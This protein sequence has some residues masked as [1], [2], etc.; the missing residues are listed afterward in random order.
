M[1]G[2]G[3]DSTQSGPPEWAVPF[4]QNYM[5]RAGAVSDLP[6][7]AYQGQ[8]L[9][10]MNPYQVGGLNATANR[11]IQGNSSVGAAN[12][13]LTDTLG[14]KYLGQGNPYLQQQIDASSQDLVRNYNT[15]I[16]PQFDAAMTRS[17]SFGNSGIQ[18]VGQAAQNDLQKN[19]ANISTG[20]RYQNYGDERNRQMQGTS[21]APA[22]ANQD[23]VDTQALS[24]VGDVFNRYGQAQRNIDYENFQEA[25]DYPKNQLATLGSALG[26]NMGQTTTGPQPNKAAGTLGGAASGA[27]IGSQVMPGWGTAI[28]AGVGGLMGG[29]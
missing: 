25:R 1:S 13:N 9:E 26:M 20:M 3:S 7:Q 29:K 10:A 23:Y 6:Y 21:L 11:A 18:E 14:G 15:A 8:R 12:Q 4:F 2:G 22:I 17:G 24:G 27:A 28:G 16:K 19:L 5:N